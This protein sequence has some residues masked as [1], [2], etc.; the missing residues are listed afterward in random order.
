MAAI[1]VLGRPRAVLRSL[2]APSP[3]AYLWRES[4]LASYLLHLGSSKKYSC[5]GCRRRKIKCTGEQPCRFCSEHGYEC[6]FE[7]RT[8]P[9]A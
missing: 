8:R 6:I 1:A 4:I 9:A 2:G 5:L 7:E 3:V